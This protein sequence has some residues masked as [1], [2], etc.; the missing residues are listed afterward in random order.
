MCWIAALIH[1][2]AAFGQEGEVSPPPPEDTPAVE[3]SPAEGAGPG[4]EADLD[5]ARRRFARGVALAE[6]G[7][8]DAAIVELNASYRL[9]PRPNTLYNIAQCQERL[10][11]YDLALQAYREYLEVAPP[12][13]PGHAAVE[14]A[15]RLLSSLLGTLHVRTNVA[16]EVWIDDR[17]SGEAPGDVP[18]PAGRHAVELRAEGYLPARSEVEIA[19][20][21]EREIDVTLEVARQEV[22]IH[23]HTTERVGISSVYFW[24]TTGVALASAAVAGG[25]G[26]WTLSLRDDVEAEDPRLRTQDD[27]DRIDDAALLTDVFWGVAGGVAVAAVVLA[28]LTDWG[29]RDESGEPASAF[30]VSPLAG[31]GDAGLSLG[32]AW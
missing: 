26:I 1:G 13:D 7:D 19:G 23:E 32:G 17:R 11:R 22:T 14:T 9:A 2:G 4:A 25:L 3:A 24:L 28:F 15:M 12:D 18:V 29:G 10:H 6:A 8:C 27:L 21:E 20:G 5:E 16:A 31:R 30:R